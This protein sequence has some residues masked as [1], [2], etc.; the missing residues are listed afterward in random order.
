MAGRHRIRV[1]TLR[2]SHL[3]FTGGVGALVDLPNFSAIVLGLDEWKYL[4]VPDRNEIVE[5]RMLEAVRRRR[6]NRGVTELRAA[7][8]LE[9]P[10]NDP[11]DVANRTGVPIRPFPS[12]LRCTACNELR[13]VESEAFSFENLNAGRPQDARFVHTR[14]SGRSRKKPLAVTAR[15]VLACPHGHLDDFPYE[16]FVHHGTRCPEVP[17]PALRMEDRGGNLGANV[18][19]TCLGCKAQRN[20]REALGARGEATLPR[21]RGRHP[22]LG[23]FEPGGCGAPTKLLVV[24]ASNQWFA[25]TLSLL[26]VPRTEASALATT[27]EQNWAVLEGIVTR[28]LLDFLWATNHPVVHELEQWPDRDE[29]WKAMEDQ[30]AAAASTDV[31]DTPWTSTDLLTPEWE[32]LTAPHPPEPTPDFTLHRDP[33]GVPAGLEGIWQDVVQVERLREVRALVGFT[34]LDAPDPE[35]P[36]LVTVA[37]LSRQD[38]TW[39]PA[40]QVRGEGLFLRVREDLLAGWEARVTGSA[41]LAAHREAY[42]RF[43]MNRYSARLPGQFDPDKNWPG[44]RYLAL[45]TLS[46]LLIR[47]IAA[48]CGYSSAGIRERIYS[49]PSSGQSE[50]QPRSGILLYTAVPDAEG[51]LGGLVSLGEPEELVR[52]TRSALHGALHCSSDPLCSERL[53]REPEDFLHGAACHVCLFVSETTCERGN[54]FLDRRFVVPLGDEPDLALF[55]DLL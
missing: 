17:N 9:N 19:L 36:D 29:I 18:R 51:T 48:E 14:C 50:G 34:R 4:N 33:P 10:H 46:H 37:P 54:R 21:C 47:A 45:H 44:A 7:P 43:R 11:D 25:R 12:H 55:R 27:V 52:I 1:G 31:D 41:A 15:F 13:L 6:E 28:E 53:P 40:A 3:M 2:P 49:T 38:P 22:H 5:P 26:S 16:E 35:D 23:T 20:I 30:R 32:V 39:V 24:G 8:H 42:R